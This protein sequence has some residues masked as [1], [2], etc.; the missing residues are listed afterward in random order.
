[1][2]MDFWSD[3]DTTI[4]YK[5]LLIDVSAAITI[6][7]IPLIF[8]FFIIENNALKRNLQEAKRMNKLL[9]E[10][11]IQEEKGGDA[12]TLSGD[13]KESICVLPDNIMYMESSGNYVDVCYREE[14]NMKH[15]L[16]RSTIKQ[17]DEMMEKYGCFVRCHRAYIVSV[18]KIMNINGNAQG[19]RLNLEDTQQE[20][21]VSRT[22]LKDFKSFLNKEN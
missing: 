8:G 19:Y 14:G 17:M 13:T 2:R 21:P 15:K 6:V 4:F 18:N 3:L 9:S 7:I 16:L 12:I 1:M 11:N 22:Y 20:I 5:M 10:R